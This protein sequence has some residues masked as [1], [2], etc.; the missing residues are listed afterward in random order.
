[1]DGKLGEAKSLL[2]G[3]LTD[4]DVKVRELALYYFS[5][6]GAPATPEV[7]SALLK[8]AKADP[9]PYARELALANL[10]SSFGATARVQ[11]ATREAMRDRD[12]AV[13]ARAAVMLAALGAAPGT[14]AADRAQILRDVTAFFRG[15][16]T[17]GN[18]SDASWGWR[19]VGNG[20]LLFGEDGRKVLLGIM[21]EKGDRQLADLA[22]RVL[23]LK[24][25]N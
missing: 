23:Y 13:A 8:A 4:P 15:Y 17:G 10:R 5:Q 22:W 16:G 18:R 11:T 2:A 3:K 25:G 7:E 1:K 6:I 9:N 21:K 14:P 24:Q 19:V 20:V 12:A